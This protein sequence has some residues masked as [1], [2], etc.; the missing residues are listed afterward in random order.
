MFKTLL[1]PQV[2]VVT[3]EPWMWNTPVSPEEEA[4]IVRAVEK[5]RREFR[6]GRHAAKA[7][8]EAFGVT[9]FRL[10]PGKGREPVW[11]Q[12]IVGAITHTGQ[13]CAVAVAS[14]TDCVSLGIDAEQNDPLKDEL[15][16][17]ICTK[18]ELDWV[19]EY[20]SKGFHWVSKLI[21]SA[22]ESIHKV[23]YPLNY[24]TLDFL[25]AELNIDIDQRTFQARIIKPYDNAKTPIFE[26]TGNFAVDPQHVYSA[27]YL[28]Q[29]SP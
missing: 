16:P 27:I 12:N 23:Y 5:R 15:K 4:I 22:K 8:L 6:A 19:T 28:Q 9:Q 14:T 20:E 2:K 29:G 11:P 13:Y 7:A 1:P 10:L 21:F 18:R 25:D 24:Y 17:M 3:S 26:L